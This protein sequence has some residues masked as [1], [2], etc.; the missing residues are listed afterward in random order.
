MRVAVSGSHGTGKTTLISAFLA[1][2]PRYRDAPE[3]FETLADD[4]DLASCEEGPTPE[5]LQALVEYTV[6]ELALHTLGACVIHERSPVDYLA[7]AAA[8][9]RGAW[10]QGDIDGFLRIHI[11]VVRASLAHLD[12]IALLPVSAAGPIE[13][14][15]GEDP[16]F[17]KRV[18]ERLRRAL[19][20]DEHGLFADGSP[21]VV[22][23]SPSPESQLA[24]LLRLTQEDRCR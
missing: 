16:G 4:I 24:E 18:D 15:P 7:Y 20:D 8:A 3:A 11:P 5:G 12:L 21:T 23:L 17:R 13:A 22:E 2:R 14:R 1:Q 10:S 6:A 9:R 19:L